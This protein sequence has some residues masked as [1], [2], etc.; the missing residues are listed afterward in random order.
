MRLHSRDVCLFVRTQEQQDPSSSRVHTGK[1]FSILAF[2]SCVQTQEQQDV[3]EF[4][5][6][7]LEC[8]NK[9]LQVRWNKW[10]KSFW[11]SW[12]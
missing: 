11:S 12:S 2:V 3:S 7:L 5:S 6:L 9:R 1:L 4:N 8:I 10:V